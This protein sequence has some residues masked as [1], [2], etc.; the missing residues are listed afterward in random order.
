MPLSA[1]RRRSASVALAFPARFSSSTSAA[2][3][4]SLSWARRKAP[5]SRSAP[6][7]SP[8]APGGRHALEVEVLGE[9]MA[10][11]PLG[12]HAGLLCTELDQIEVVDRR[13]QAEELVF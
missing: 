5:T 9:R 10:G 13:Q 6:R 8:S 11:K 2:R 3:A 1:R 12:E 7:C 4:A